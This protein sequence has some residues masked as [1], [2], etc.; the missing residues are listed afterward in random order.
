MPPKAPIEARRSTPRHSS[1]PRSP[2]HRCRHWRLRRRSGPLRDAARDGNVVRRAAV[3]TPPAAGSARLPQATLRCRFV[4]VP[5]LLPYY[6]PRNSV[7]SSNFLGLATFPGRLKLYFRQRRFRQHRPASHASRAL[8]I[9]SSVTWLLRPPLLLPPS[10]FWGRRLTLRIALRRGAGGP[11]ARGRPNPGGTIEQPHSRSRTSRLS[12]PRKCVN[13]SDD[14]SI[15]RLRTLC[16]PPRVPRKPRLQFG[17]HR[18]PFV[19]DNR[20]VGRVSCGRVAGGHVAA[21]NP[22]E[23]R[24]DPLD[25]V[26]RALIALVGLEAHAM[27]LPFL[28]SVRQQQQFRFGIASRALRRRRNPGGADLDGIG[29]LALGERRV[30]GPAPE[31]REIAGRPDDRM[32]EADREGIAFAAL[33]LRQS[34]G[35]VDSHLGRR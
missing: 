5:D 24:A 26:A 35:H 17:S 4:P 12:Q 31:E 10:G 25:C 22:V 32:V 21:Q 13:Q 7:Y 18:G 33:P 2:P 9:A 20:V 27:N 11:A 23:L 29:R 19:G 16:L 6:L 28:E 34:G 15:N 3:Q 14:G 30:F 1:R 8:V